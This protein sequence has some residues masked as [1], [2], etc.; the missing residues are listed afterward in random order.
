MSTAS[1]ATAHRQR[2]LVSRV[3]ATILLPLYTH[4][5]PPDAY[6]RVEI[7]TAATGFVSPEFQPAG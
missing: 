1:A 7:V 4:Y 6:G 3:L 2:S 5:L